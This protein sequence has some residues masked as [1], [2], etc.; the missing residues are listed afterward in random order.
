MMMGRMKP[1]RSSRAKKATLTLIETTSRLQSRDSRSAR[2]EVARLREVP[3]QRIVQI[4]RVRGPL[5]G[6]LCETALEERERGEP[7]DHEL[8]AGGER[9]VGRAVA[10]RQRRVRIE[11]DAL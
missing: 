5:G 7:R 6:V 8:A 9:R 2:G 3:C 11:H 4:R 1:N 10:A